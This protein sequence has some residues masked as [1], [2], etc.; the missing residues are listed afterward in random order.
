MKFG[1]GERTDDSGGYILALGCL[2][3]SLIESPLQ[4][5]F[6]YLL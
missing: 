1:T 2:C 5:G 4:Q 6:A 3:S